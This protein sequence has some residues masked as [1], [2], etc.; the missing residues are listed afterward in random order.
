M[1]M[2]RQATI[3]LH[4]KHCI[5]LDDLDVKSLAVFGSGA[6]DETQ[7]SSDVNLLVEEAFSTHGD[8]RTNL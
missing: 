6:R 1:V 7:D 8:R 3:D 2:A 4:Q 5:A